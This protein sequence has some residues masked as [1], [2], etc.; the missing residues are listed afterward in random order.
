MMGGGGFFGDSRLNGPGGGLF[1]NEAG[2]GFLEDKLDVASLKRDANQYAVSL[3][4]Y[5]ATTTYIKGTANAPRVIVDASSHIELLDE[6]LRVDASRYGIT[7]IA[8]EIT[9]LSSI[10]SHASELA[11]AHP[12]AVYGFLGGEHSITP[13]I[14]EGLPREEIGIVWIDAHAD[15][16]RS[17]HGSE[18][19]H[20]CAGFNSLKF[21][22][23]V[24]IGVRS[25]AEEEAAFLDSADRVAC[26]RDW[27]DPV[28]DAIRALPARIYLSVD[29]DGFSPTL[30]RAVGT[31]EPGGLMWD[32]VLD[33]LD[34]LFG[35]KDVF[36]FDVVELCPH[37]DDV[38]SSYTAARLVYKIMAYH[39][40]HKLQGK[41]R[42]G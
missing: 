12:N 17:F 35:E 41:P 20:A 27:T 26:F 19:N 9:D 31:P 28:K 37:A 33:I 18:V 30:V 36:A 2:Q 16:R 34:F 5:E 32:E 3:I 13:A 40:F 6:T 11:T 25:L 10:T 23:I 29:M 38:V 14:L 7:T 42:R 1:V 15:L 24:Q 4:P 22:R 39:A 21:G 8:P